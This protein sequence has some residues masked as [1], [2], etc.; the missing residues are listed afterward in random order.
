M[1]KLG[2]AIAMLLGVGCGLPTDDQIQWY[3][4]FEQCDLCDWTTTRGATRVTTYHEGEHALRLDVDAGA[5]HALDIVRQANNNYDLSD[6]GNWLELSTDCQGPGELGL[7]ATADGVRIAVFLD[8]LG[9]DQF[10]RHRLNFP[11][12]ERTLPV[13]F[14]AIDLEVGTLP[15]H[16][17]N[18]QI[19][20]SGGAYGY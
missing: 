4:D 7:V 14:V 1:L 5:S 8:D 12:V 20:I 11:P 2:V 19:R 3:D 18:P 16:I 15:C 17:D 9:I 6:D 10:V 13:H